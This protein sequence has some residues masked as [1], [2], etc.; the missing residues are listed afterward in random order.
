M[1]L[2]IGVLVPTREAVLQGAKDVDALLAFAERAEQLGFDS[3]WVGDS[4]LARPRHEP[5]ALLGAIAART[6]R[7]ELGTAVLIA[8][9][10]HP[11]ALAQAAA[12]V[13][14]IAHGR[15]ILGLGMAS[16]GAPIEAE[17]AAVGVPHD[18]RAGR[19]RECLKLLPQLWTARPVTFQGRYWTLEGATLL[20]APVRPGGPQ[21]WVGG[22]GPFS[23]KC[24][25]E[26]AAGWFPNSPTPEAFRAGWQ[27]VAAA[28]KAVGRPLPTR[29]FY[30]TVT[31]DDDPTRAQAEMKAFMERYYP[32][33]YEAMSQR[34]G[35]AAGTVETVLWRTREF[36]AEGIDHLV[37]RF[38]SANQAGQL[39]RAGRDLLPALRPR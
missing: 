19:L 8:P 36:L 24:A 30:F 6:R 5:M 34:Q 37:L 4:L 31:V 17:F 18:K 13:D 15:L 14:Q 39:E 22:S 2:K 25:G 11:L 27:R 28:A 16:S 23:L 9:L 29:A 38:G 35:C 20:P 1:A 21:L 32:L 10:R 12:T 33:P 7:V 3:V 26:L